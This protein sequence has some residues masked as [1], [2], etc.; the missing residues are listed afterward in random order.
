MK[1]LI[2]LFALPFIALAQQQVEIK[3]NTFYTNVQDGRGKNI[4]ISFSL[5]DEAIEKIL[6]SDS[7]SATKKDS[8]F[9]KVNIEK[10][11][12]T[13]TLAIH[14]FSLVNGA[15]FSTGSELKN[16]TS[17]SIEENSKG[18]IYCSGDKIAISF[19]FQAQNSKGIIIYAESITK[20]SETLIIQ[21]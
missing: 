17:L 12:I 4:D 5:S 10:R 19:P 1:T 9:L 7:Y 20:D 18:M 13:D 8:N 2:I 14:L 16:P 11:G 15:V 3:N 21:N 6:N